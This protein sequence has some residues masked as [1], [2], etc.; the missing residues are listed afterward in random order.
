L[1]Y[2]REIA[3]GSDSPQIS[4]HALM[5]NASDHPIR[6]SVQSVTQYDTATAPGSAE[7]NHNFWAFT[8]A[9]P[10]SSYLDGYHFRLGLSGD[11]FVEVRNG[12]FRLH[13]SYFEREIWIDS[14][15][16]WLAVFDGA[17]RYAMVERFPHS[18]DAEYPGKA[19]VIFYTNGRALEFDKQGEPTLTAPDPLE[20]PYYMEAEVNSPMIRLN[21]GETYGF[22]T[23]WLPVR[24]GNEPSAVTEIGVIGKPLSATRTVNGVSLSGSFGVFAPGNLT[25]FLLDPQGKQIGSVAL[26]SANP[27]DAVEL[28][29]TVT[30]PAATERITLHLIDE[31]GRDRGAIGEAKVAGAF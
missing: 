7:Y 15:A 6:W 11:P 26:G 27:L 17:S 23:A 24:V 10:D 3:V 28:N 25:A 5:R 13:W 2:S 1:Q 8:P 29:K 20:L 31:H 9:N 12:M 18:A 21:P 19:T 4:F 22:D 16:G 30:V 14:T